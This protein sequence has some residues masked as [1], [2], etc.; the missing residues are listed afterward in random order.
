MKQVYFTLPAK[1]L[2]QKGN[3]GM[4]AEVSKNTT[5]QLQWQC[6]VKAICDHKI[7]RFKHVNEKTW[8]VSEIHVIVHFLK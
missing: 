5:P 4:V 8:T 7:R 3:H 2:A 1:P 6:E